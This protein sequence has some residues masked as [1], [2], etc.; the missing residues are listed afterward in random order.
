M[1]TPYK[2]SKN[3]FITEREHFS[4]TLIDICIVIL[5]TM[6]KNAWKIR[7]QLQFRLLLLLFTVY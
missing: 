1:E 7:L 3:A 4:I 2:P 5:D 6:K